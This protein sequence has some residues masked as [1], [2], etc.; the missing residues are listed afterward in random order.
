VLRI[1]IDQCI[2][3]GA[4]G[5]ADVRVGQ[6]AGSDHFATINDLS[7]AHATQK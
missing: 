4:V 1:R 6:S 3:S 5:I 7:V 2:V